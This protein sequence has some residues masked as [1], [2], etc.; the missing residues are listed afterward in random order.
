M[1]NPLAQDEQRTNWQLHPINFGFFSYETHLQP[2]RRIKAHRFVQNPIEVRNPGK[3][4]GG[5][6]ATS[7]HG[8]NLI[9]QCD[10]NLWRLGEQIKHTDVANRRSLLTTYPRCQSL[11][12]HLFTREY[13]VSLSSVLCTH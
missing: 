4:I 9:L 10:T 12:M 1:H 2:G 6:L 11:T 3:V 8:A 13:R 7:Q 5:W